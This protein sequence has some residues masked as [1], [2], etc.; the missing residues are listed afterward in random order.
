MHF[1]LLEEDFT[2]VVLTLISQVKKYVQNKKKKSSKLSNLNIITKSENSSAYT[3][4]SIKTHSRK[5][6]TTSQG[7]ECKKS[8]PW[9][10]FNIQILKT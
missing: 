3:T 6:L 10:K 4:D 9:R 7:K 5:R 1:A 2:V 8:D